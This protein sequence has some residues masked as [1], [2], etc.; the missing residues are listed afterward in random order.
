MDTKIKNSTVDSEAAINQ[1][2]KMAMGV[3]LLKSSPAPS[4]KSVKS[5]GGGGPK[6]AA[7]NY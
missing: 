1:H 6:P 5:T 4:N 2:S 7:K 3:P